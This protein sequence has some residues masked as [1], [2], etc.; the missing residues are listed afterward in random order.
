[1]KTSSEWLTKIDC[2]PFVTSNLT[3]L[4]DRA[5]FIKRGTVI[6][7]PACKAAKLSVDHTETLCTALLETKYKERHDKLCRLIHFNI[8]NTFKLIKVEV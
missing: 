8:A 4:Q 6:K 2:S 3:A 7:C 1:M 5:L